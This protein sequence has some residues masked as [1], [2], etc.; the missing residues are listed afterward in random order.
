MGN[1]QQHANRNAVANRYRV[2]GWAADGDTNVIALADR[3][4]NA[5]GSNVNALANGYSDGDPNINTMAD[6]CANEYAHTRIGAGN[7]SQ[8]GS[9]LCLHW[10]M[11]RTA[12]GIDVCDKRQ[13]EQ[14][15]REDLPF[16]R[17]DVLRPN[18]HQT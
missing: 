14:R 4:A 2:A 1:E 7:R 18:R 12:T 9:A 3:H 11:C 16:A 13:C 5:V 10:G 15:R 8:Y 17:R 6:R